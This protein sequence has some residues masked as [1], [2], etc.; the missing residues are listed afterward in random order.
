V[1]GND[2]PWRRENTA[3]EPHSRTLATHNAATARCA[4]RL[5]R[6][7]RLRTR[8]V[9]LTDRSRKNQSLQDAI[10]YTVREGRWG[11]CFRLRHP[12]KQRSGAT[13]GNEDKTRKA[14]AVVDLM[15]LQPQEEHPQGLSN[16]AFEELFTPDKPVVFA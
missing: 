10:G 5:G 7:V 13:C 16:A 2:L 6:Q 12:S 11:S 14:T 9:L 4:T 8:L 1:G 3:V 15:K